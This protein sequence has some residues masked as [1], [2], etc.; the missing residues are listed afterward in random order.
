MHRQFIAKNAP[1]IAILGGILFMLIGFTID[2]PSGPLGFI[3]FI[4][5]S[6]LYSLPYIPKIIDALNRL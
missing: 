6:I 5:G 1:A 2:I 4:I 3:L